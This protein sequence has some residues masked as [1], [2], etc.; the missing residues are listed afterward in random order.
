MTTKLEKQRA[1]IQS[2]VEELAKNFPTNPTNIESIYNV[3]T[4]HL[5]R[6]PFIFGAAFAFAPEISN[7]SPFVFRVEKG[8]EQK[9][10]AA[11]LDYTQAL[12]YSVSVEIGQ[13]V[14]SVPYFDIGG[15]GED[16]LLMTYSS[17]LFNYEDSSLL[18]ILTSDLL[19]AQLEKPREGYLCSQT[20]FCLRFS[21]I[22]CF[23]CRF[24]P[25]QQA[26]TA[27]RESTLP[28]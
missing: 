27:L 7:A 28:Y 16:V 24:N 17:P 9:D 20:S 12:R 23:A 6:N 15:A 22:R 19:I 3:L 26:N 2:A 14:W 13:A 21:R 5:N 10:I 8:L 4:D 1:E 18:G 11:E 25:E